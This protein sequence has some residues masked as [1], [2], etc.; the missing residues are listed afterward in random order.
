MSELMERRVTT[1]ITDRERGLIQSFIRKHL[2]FSVVRVRFPSVS[3]SFD[4]LPAAAAVVAVSAHS[5]FTLIL[6][7]KFCPGGRPEC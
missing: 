2:C 3:A 4:C 5:A 1:R 7:T 6:K